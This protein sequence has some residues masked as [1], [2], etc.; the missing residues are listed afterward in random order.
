MKQA[1]VSFSKSLFQS[2][3]IAG[4]IV[5]LAVWG[6]YTMVTSTPAW[7]KPESELLD[8]IAEVSAGKSLKPVKW[9]NGAK[10]AVAFSLDVDNQ[11]SLLADEGSMF[12]ELTGGLNPAMMSRAEY[13]GRVGLERLTN[14]FD[15]HD[16]PATYFMP[17]ISLKAAPQ[18]ADVIKRS[19]N[20]EVA[21]HG[22]VHELQSDMSPK[23]IQENLV[24][25]SDYLG[26]VFG[27]KPVGHRAP[28]LISEQSFPVLVDMGLLYDSSLLSD[29]VPF[30]VN[31][32]G[33]PS[34]LVE[35]PVN[36]GLEDSQLDHQFNFFANGH[37]P[38]QVLEIFKAEFDMAYE[39]GTT[40][41]FILHPHITGQRSRAAIIEEII[42][43]MKSKPDVWFT[44]HKDLAQYARDHSISSR[45]KSE[46]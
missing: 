1:L 38:K 15:K 21:L 30:E 4:I 45:K 10:V 44:T 8:K 20:H 14:I 37:T 5:A 17:A 36:L 24:R 39:E 2:T 28:V 46:Q 9:P 22:W 16:V 32:A 43:Y 11:S 13:G 7:E 27:E 6:G 40:M 42:Q 3:L 35:V 23:Q 33:K 29:D 34:G 31:L 19:G 18:M 25:A 12:S 26:S 41:V